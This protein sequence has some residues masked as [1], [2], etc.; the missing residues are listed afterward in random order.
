[1]VGLG[2]QCWFPGRLGVLVNL[3]TTL[4]TG[5]AG[6]ASSPLR[7]CAPELSVVVIRSSRSSASSVD[8]SVDGSVD[9]D[10][11]SC[12]ARPLTASQQRRTNVTHRRS[13]PPNIDVG[14]FT[15]TVADPLSF[16]AAQL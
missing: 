15:A 8:A 10:L 5:G 1:L 11:G 2:W 6:S 12:L 13:P 14:G 7:S 16:L 4:V 3:L 9:G